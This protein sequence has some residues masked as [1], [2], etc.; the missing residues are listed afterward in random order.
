[1]RGLIWIAVSSQSQAAADKISL[2]EQRRACEQYARDNGIDIVDTLIVPGESRAAI[3]IVEFDKLPAAYHK[4]REYWQRGGIEALIVYEFSRLG[5]SQSLLTYVLENMI[6]NGIDVHVVEGGAGVISNDNYRGHIA[7]GGF[8]TTSH[9]DSFRKKVRAARERKAALGLPTGGHVPFTH[10]IVRDEKGRAQRVIVNPAM[11]PFLMDL[12]RLLL[13]RIAW[14]RLPDALAE[15]GHYSDDGTPYHYYTIYGAVHTPVFWG[16]QGLGYGALQGNPGLWVFDASIDAPSGVMMWYDTELTEPAYTGALADAVQDEL[17]RRTSSAVRAHGD[18]GIRAFTALIICQAC[19]SS[20]QMRSRNAYDYVYYGCRLAQKRYGYQCD[21]TA[22]IRTDK[23]QAYITKML[24]VALSDG[25]QSVIQQNG[26]TETNEADILADEK[27]AIEKQI[28]TLIRKQAAAPGELSD[29]YDDELERLAQRLSVISTRRNKLEHE[30]KRD[31]IRGG[32]LYALEELRSK[33][34]IDW[35]WS[36][37]QA[38][39]N[40]LLQRILGNWRLVLN[41]GEIVGL[42]NQTI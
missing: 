13:D 38:E 22:Y 6:R 9:M 21:H 28:Q 26:Q 19:G 20:V 35:L 33:G 31:R 8:A 10:K 41:D 5:R 12:A 32:Q 34:G 15:L 2:P 42:I 14:E 37:P 1:M 16:N 17:R 36:Q 7:I 40:Q 11:R 27:T 4:L 3:D 39:Q 23:I 18:G 25:L 24:E 30:A 29:M